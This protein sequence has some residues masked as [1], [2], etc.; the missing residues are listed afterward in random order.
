[1]NRSADDQAA[2]T[3]VTSVPLLDLKRQHDPLQDELDEIRVTLAEGTDPVQ[4]ASI[5]AGKSRSITSKLP[6]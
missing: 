1:M 4:S 6:S 3:P 2:N 5:I